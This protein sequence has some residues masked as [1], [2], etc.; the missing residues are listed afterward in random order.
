MCKFNLNS[1]FRKINAF[2]IPEK[3]KELISQGFFFQRVNLCNVMWKLISHCTLR[4]N[5]VKSTFLL[6]EV[7]NELIS[8]VFFFF[9]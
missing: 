3:S 5:F 8:R 1:Q 9:Q 6:K 2:T 4:Q 7:T